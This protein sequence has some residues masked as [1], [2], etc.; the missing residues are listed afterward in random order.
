MIP[1]CNAH[2]IGLIP[3]APLNGGDL[4]RSFNA[5]S[6]RKDSRQ[7]IKTYS[8]ADKTIINRVEEIARK[9]GWTMSQVALAWIDKRVSSPI[10]GLSSVR[11]LIFSSLVIVIVDLNLQVER[12]EASVMTGKELTEEESRYLEEPWV[13]RWWNVRHILM[14]HIDSYEPKNVRGHE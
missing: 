12:L 4:A 13:Y 9:R 6:T 14:H 3:W 7:G 10:V 8:E 5:T 2:G 11:A 1:Y